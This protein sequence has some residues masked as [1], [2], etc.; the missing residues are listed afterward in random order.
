MVNQ[1]SG[2][3]WDFDLLKNRHKA[4]RLH[5]EQQPALLIGSVV[6]TAFSALQA[7]NEQRRDPEVVKRE[8]IRAMVHLRSVCELYQMQLDE[9]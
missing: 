9:G 5:D 4:W 3:P 7:V 2:E 1:E 6:C 8:W